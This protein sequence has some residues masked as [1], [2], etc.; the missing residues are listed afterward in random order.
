MRFIFI[1]LITL[2]VWTVSCRSPTPRPEDVRIPSVF[3][4]D[5][6]ARE[7]E[8]VDFLAAG[9]VPDP[10][11]EADRLNPDRYKNNGV[12]ISCVGRCPEGLAIDQESFRVRWETTFDDAGIYRFAMR[13][14][15]GSVTKQSDVYLV[16]EDTD[17]PPFFVGAEQHLV[18]KES[19]TLEAA[20]NAADLDGDDVV[21]NCLSCPTGLS[22]AGSK[23]LW[24]PAYG[25]A[26]IYRLD[27]AV[28]SRPATRPVLAPAS[29]EPLVINRE[30]DLLTSG[31]VVVTVLKK[32][33]TAVFIAGGR[34]ISMKENEKES[35]DLL[36]SDADGDPATFSCVAP[37][38]SFVS[39][40]AS[41]RLDVSPTYSDAGHYDV[42]VAMS[43]QNSPVA[44]TVITIDVANVNRPPVYDGATIFLTAKEGQASYFMLSRALDPDLEDRLRYACDTVCPPGFMLTGDGRAS[45]IPPFSESGIKKFNIK[46]S[47]QTAGVLIP[48]Q[49]TVEE[50]NRAPFFNPG[51]QSMEINAFF[52]TQYRFYADDPDTEDKGRLRFYCVLC[53]TGALMNAMTGELTWTPDQTQKGTHELSIM[54]SDNRAV[55]AL[56]QTID[57]L[58]TVRLV[59]RAPRF[60]SSSTVQGIETVSIGIVKPD[61]SKAPLKIQALD[62][63]GD[64]VSYRCVSTIAPSFSSQVPGCPSGLSLN[65]STGE[66]SW[67]PSSGQRGIYDVSFEA[68]SYP[69]WSSDPADAKTSTLQ[70][71]FYIKKFNHAPVTEDPSETFFSLQEMG[72]E[73]TDY[74]SP[75]RS[76]IS[77]KLAATDP[78][79]D[80]LYFDCLNC[81]LGMTIDHQ[82][83]EVRWLPSYDQALPGND[84]YDGIFFFV[85]DGDSDP[86]TQIPTKEYFP[87]F[88]FRVKNVNRPPVVTSDTLTSYAVYEEG[89]ETASQNSPKGFPLL[90]TLK[91][92]DPDGEPLVYSCLS[93][94]EPGMVLSAAGGTLTW[95]PTYDYVRGGLE[96]TTGEVRLRAT[97]GEGLSTDFTP[98]VVTVSNVNRAP[99]LT[100]PKLSF[101]VYEGGHAGVGKF[102][103]DLWVDTPTTEPLQFQMTAIDPDGDPVTFAC[104]EN[105]IAGMVIDSKLGMVSLTP[106]FCSTDDPALCDNGVTDGPRNG[107]RKNN[108]AY[109]G[110]RFS[111]SDGPQTSLSSAATFLIKNYDRPPR[112][113]AGTS[114]VRVSEG[115]RYE[116]VLRATDPDGDPVSINCDSLKGAV[117]GISPI[118]KESGLTGCAKTTASSYG[119]TDAVKYYWPT[120]GLAAP[121]FGQVIGLLSITSPRYACLDPGSLALKSDSNQVLCLLSGGI[122]S[123]MSGATIFSVSSLGVKGACQNSD[124]P[125]PSVG[126]CDAPTS[127]EPYRMKLSA[128][129]ES[130]IE[131]GSSKSLI[132]ER[133]I[134]VTNVDRHGL[135]IQAGDE[136]SSGPI[137]EVGGYNKLSGAEMTGEVLLTTEQWPYQGLNLYDVDGQFAC[138]NGSCPEAAYAGTF[139]DGTYIYC[140][141]SGPDGCPLG[142]EVKQF[143]DKKSSGGSLVEISGSCRY[144]RPLS[145]QPGCSGNQGITDAVSGHPG[146]TLSDLLW[147]RCSD[148]GSIKFNSVFM[149]SAKLNN[150][151]YR[152]KMKI[153]TSVHSLDFSPSVYPPA[154]KTVMLT[155]QIV[156]KDR[157]P[158]FTSTTGSICKEGELGG[159][160]VLGTVDQMKRA[161]LPG[162]TADCLPA[163]S[164]GS[165]ESLPGFVGVNPTSLF[166][167]EPTGNY[168]KPFASDGGEVWMTTP[169]GTTDKKSFQ[170]LS[171][172]RDS[173]PQ[174]LGGKSD[175][176][177]VISYRMIGCRTTRD[178]W[179][180][181]TATTPPPY[182]NEAPRWLDAYLKKSSITTEPFFDAVSQGWFFQC[183]PWITMNE[184]K[185]L[186]SVSPTA[187]DQSTTQSVDLEKLCYP[188]DR[189]AFG[190]YPYAV[191]PINGS[192]SPGYTI[193]RTAKDFYVVFT[194][195]A[196][197][198]NTVD[199]LDN[200]AWTNSCGKAGRSDG[201]SLL[202]VKVDVLDGDRKPTPVSFK[203]VKTNLAEGYDGTGAFKDSLGR[204]IDEEKPAVMNRWTRPHKIRT[205]DTVT[206][207]PRMTEDRRDQDFWGIPVTTESYSADPDS[208]FRKYNVMPQGRLASGSQFIASEGSWVDVRETDSYYVV[209]ESRDPDGDA[210]YFDLES[211]SKEQEL[212]G[213]ITYESVSS[214]DGMDGQ[215]YNTGCDA[216]AVCRQVLRVRPKNRDASSDR[217]MSLSHK[218][219]VFPEPAKAFGLAV[220]ACSAPSSMHPDEKIDKIPVPQSDYGN[221]ALTG[222]KICSETRNPGYDMSALPKPGFPEVRLTPSSPPLAGQRWDGYVVLTTRLHDVDRLPIVSLAPSSTVILKNTTVGGQEVLREA[223]DATSMCSRLASGLNY[224]VQGPSVNPTGDGVTAQPLD[225]IFTLT[226]YDRADLEGRSPV[227]DADGYVQWT[228]RPQLAADLRLS[229]GTALKTAH[230]ESYYDGAPEVAADKTGHYS[231]RNRL[232]LDPASGQEVRVSSLFFADNLAAPTETDPSSP[233]RS[234][235]YDFNKLTTIPM[236]ASVTYDDGYG[237]MTPD[238]TQEISVQA[239]IAG[240]YVKPCI[241]WWAN[242][243]YKTV[244]QP[245]SYYHMNKIRSFIYGGRD[246][247]KSGPAIPNYN[248]FIADTRPVSGSRCL[249]SGSQDACTYRRIGDTYTP[250]SEFFKYTRSYSG[251]GN[252]VLGET[253]VDYPKSTSSG[254]GISEARG[255]S[256]YSLPWLEYASSA[257]PAGGLLRVHEVADAINVVSIS[258]FFEY[259]GVDVTSFSAPSLEIGGT[260]ASLSLDS[261][262]AGYFTVK[263]ITFPGMWNFDYRRDQA[264]TAGVS[265]LSGT[266][267]GLVEGVIRGNFTGEW[268]FGGQ[269]PSYVPKSVDLTLRPSIG[270]S[271]RDGIEES[272]VIARDPITVRLTDDYIKPHLAPQGED[273]WSP[274][275]C[276]SDRDAANN[277]CPEKARTAGVG[278][279]WQGY[280]DGD[281][282]FGL[283]DIR[284][285]AAF[286]NPNNRHTGIAGN[287]VGTERSGLSMFNYYGIVFSEEKVMLQNFIPKPNSWPFNDSKTSV[288]LDVIRND[289]WNAA[290]GRPQGLRVGEIYGLVLRDE[291]YYV[292]PGVLNGETKGFTSGAEK[293]FSWRS[294]FSTASDPYNSHYP[295]LWDRADSNAWLTNREF[296]WCRDGGQ[297]D[298][299]SVSKEICSQGDC[300][301]ESHPYFICNNNVPIL[302]KDLL[303]APMDYPSGGGGCSGFLGCL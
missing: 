119:T 228:G 36:W 108:T 126:F 205:T 233:Y 14:E 176:E 268:N 120:A 115:G 151:P 252:D 125:A 251:G 70:F 85:V 209:L 237:A 297:A 164:D 244:R 208:P 138:F 246:S 285:P 253:A 122:W 215:S 89:H 177:G 1:F 29:D 256:L 273:Y 15:A 240:Q 189:P 192:C 211:A 154:E 104:E 106:N 271:F 38:P 73:T 200:S 17:R 72:H 150:E 222:E 221:L 100:M 128:Y 212:Q 13:S 250:A 167:S 217:Y 165:G 74:R 41:G 12:K 229:S 63:D 301:T 86:Y 118:Y 184:E 223:T 243:D 224:S 22:F 16:V 239:T 130:R 92:S 181:S 160:C 47:D 201:E 103:G 136:I 91:A 44:T 298:Y 5:L 142:I 97:D 266:R 54:V 235:T 30:S 123:D 25:T 236:K 283:V 274:L 32:D 248:D 199:G 203:V 35:L 78:D 293:G 117:G 71:R 277:G 143:C 173:S 174:V 156:N 185:G 194:T 59:D 265:S 190:V 218:S 9:A 52:L 172:D 259:G 294:D 261:Q 193:G 242:A 269:D 50:V 289:T 263:R 206:S 84:L 93:G 207:D 144:D 55:G 49:I 121:P 24:T 34:T 11:Y 216:D 214:V 146:E 153:R 163:Y 88:S 159:A 171:F 264:A 64:Q 129:S 191:K 166:V 96:R 267:F 56:S 202:A 234:A 158:V 270:A 135:P 68:I 204:G 33:R 257:T 180:P 182:K 82:T 295:L 2:E 98:F 6:K 77:F 303:P 111:A 80:A 23:I 155:I 26:G 107:A 186:V 245:G 175:T 196:C 4:I 20:I 134:Y 57:V 197:P 260:P 162:E 39:I 101:S 168:V 284:T 302:L 46:A 145:E 112:I 279:I 187:N 114:S 60:M 300:H 149:G 161:C 220:R 99:V 62:P 127:G 170:L 139:M 147:K 76:G 7:G 81:P 179:G 281:D 226:E 83:G 296:Y 230:I 31:T 132:F 18:V 258:A 124:L 288:N 58:V 272:V 141:P 94:C 105:C 178:A 28:K 198:K 137:Y 116:D 254:Y 282:Y 286:K 69:S 291:G 299:R 280:P 152:I 19:E 255:S 231:S 278:S 61:G 42:T 225:G 133:S 75:K 292:V 3:S 188:N 65:L 21:I 95:T 10:A 87:P 51:V 110:V 195:N 238:Y 287:Q 169:V 102:A 183:P 262:S 37:C 210:V 67:T 227:A 79:Q 109:A 247:E 219:D 40:S 157:P 43:Q 66:I 275:S 113:D 232:R 53:P 148:K 249:N 8:T 48:V 90:A 131:T 290:Y 140:D 213:A 241:K 276:S 45:Y 27:I